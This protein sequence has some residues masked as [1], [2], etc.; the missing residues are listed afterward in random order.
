MKAILRRVEARLS[1]GWSRP[2]A[3]PRIGV[4]HL[5]I[6]ADFHVKIRRRV[7]RVNHL[8]HWFPSQKR[9]IALDERPVE[10]AQD[11]A[12]TVADVE[13]DQQAVAAERADVLDPG[14]ERRGHQSGGAGPDHQPFADPP[15]V[16]LPAPRHDSPRRRQGERALGV[17]EAAGGGGERR[18]GDAVLL[19]VC[20]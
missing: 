18:R 15:R 4:D 14:V 2:P 10:A 8:A 13:E 20:A 1:S 9:L 5:S 17:G 6:L 12:M 3:P 16:K 7:G 11:D 19:S